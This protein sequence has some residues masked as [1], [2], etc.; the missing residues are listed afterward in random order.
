MK[1]NIKNFTLLLV[2]FVFSGVLLA[3]ESKRERIKTLR[4]G[5]FTQQ[6]KLSSADAEKFWPVYN[7]YD[8]KIYNL[9]K[10]EREE[11][12]K[13]FKDENDELT[14]S[15]A[16]ELLVKLQHLREEEFRIKEETEKKLV[17]IFNAK[18]VLLL[19]KTEFD[20]NKHLLEHSKE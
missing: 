13:I 4:T 7:E 3:Q 11:I 10:I 19:K 17:E 1:I 9:R 16:E 18:M 8:E 5:F 6:L 12:W 15:Q 2:L 14:D 20:F